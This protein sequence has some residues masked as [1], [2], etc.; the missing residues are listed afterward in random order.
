LVSVSKSTLGSTT[1]DTP[2]HRQRLGEGDHG[3][4]DDHVVHQLDRLA[5]ARR[6]AVGDLGAHAGEQR[7]H[8]LEHRGLAADHDRQRAVAG[9]LGGAGDRRVEEV[10]AAGGNGV[11][12][13]ARERDRGGA[14]VH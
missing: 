3:L 6:T 10:G 12:Q 9:R 4:G 8:P 1:P 11:G 5:R 2:R 13:L 14:H 7:S